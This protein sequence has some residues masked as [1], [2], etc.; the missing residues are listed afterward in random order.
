MTNTSPSGHNAVFD[1]QL[2]RSIDLL[3][4]LISRLK[5]KAIPSLE[6]VEICSAELKKLCQINVALKKELFQPLMTDLDN[7]LAIKPVDGN[8]NEDMQRLL[9]KAEKLKSQLWELEFEE[10]E[11]QTRPHRIISSIILRH[12]NSDEPIS[13]EETESLE[14]LQLSK[15]LSLKTII[16]ISSKGYVID[17]G[18]T[19]GNNQNPSYPSAGAIEA[20]DLLG[21]PITPTEDV[22]TE[23]P[24]TDAVGPQGTPPLEATPK[25]PVAEPTSEPESPEEEPTT[26]RYEEKTLPDAS[27]ECVIPDLKKSPY[28]QDCFCFASHFAIFDT[29]LT[30]SHVTSSCSSCERFRNK[31]GELRSKLSAFFSKLFENG[32]LGKVIVTSPEFRRR[33]NFFCLTRPAVEHISDLSEV[34]KRTD[35]PLAVRNETAEKV[36]RGISG[37]AHLTPYLQSGETPDG[38]RIDPII[39]NSIAFGF[40]VSR[41]KRFKSFLRFDPAR[42]IVFCEPRYRVFAQVGKTAG[43][44]YTIFSVSKGNI[45]ADPE[46]FREILQ[47]DGAIL[48]L[49]LTVD[50]PVDDAIQFFPEEFQIGT[51]IVGLKGNGVVILQKN[52]WLGLDVAEFPKPKIEKESASENGNEDSGAHEKSSADTE[53][54]EAADSSRPEAESSPANLQ[55]PVVDEAAAPLSE[56]RL[57]SDVPS[58]SIEPEAR[59]AATVPDS[60]D[61]APATPEMVL[62]PSADDYVEEDNLLADI[63][64]LPPDKTAVKDLAAALCESEDFSPVKNKKRGF[65]LIL[66]IL[67][68]E[69]NYRTKY[70]SDKQICTS[71]VGDA[72]LLCRAFADLEEES[73]IYHVLLKQ[74]AYATDSEIVERNYCF[75]D[76]SELLNSKFGCPVNLQQAILMRALFAPGI[77]GDY[78]LKNVAQGLFNDSAIWQNLP[79]VREVLKLLLKL[80][81][82]K[83]NKGY[84]QAMVNAICDVKDPREQLD[85]YAKEAQEL[86]RINS[87]LGQ[88]QSVFSQKLL[89][90]ESDTGVALKRLISNSLGDRELVQ[91]VLSDLS[92]DSKI[93]DAIKTAWDQRRAIMKVKGK[94]LDNKPVGG[95]VLDK[96]REALKKRIDL[97]NRWYEAT[98]TIEAPNKFKELRNKLL[99]AIDRAQKEL[100]KCQDQFAK[101]I[102]DNVLELMKQRL[103]GNMDFNRLYFSPT[104]HTGWIMLDK[105]YQPVFLN[106]HYESFVPWRNVLHHLCAEIPSLE[107]VKKK[108]GSPETYFFDNLGMFELI[109]SLQGGKFSP[110]DPPQDNVNRAKSLSEEIVKDYEGRIELAF[111]YGKI[112]EIAKET[113]RNGIKEFKEENDETLNFGFQKLF[114]SSID[115]QIEKCSQ[116][117]RKELSERIEKQQEKM[118]FP[119][120]KTVKRLIEEAKNY[121][122]AE[123]YLNRYE[124]DQNQD[125]QLI[126]D[127]NSSSDL[128]DF[129]SKDA[130]TNK[131]NLCSHTDDSFLRPE[132]LAQYF[133]IDSTDQDNSRSLIDSWNKLFAKSSCDDAKDLFTLWGF[134]VD[135]IR[136][137]ADKGKSK[138]RLT[139]RAS[140]KNLETYLTPFKEFG[141][142]PE[143]M[144]VLLVQQKMDPKGLV[145]TFNQNITSRISF[146]L[147]DKS[148]T[149]AN[150]RKITDI[151]HLDRD[152]KK[153]CIIVDK[154]LLAYLATKPQT[155]RLQALLNCALPFT[156]LNPFNGETGGVSDEMFRGRAKYLNAIM[157]SNM[158]SMLLYGGRQLGKTAILVRAANMM[159]KPADKEFAVFVP[160]KG[161]RQESNFAKI[162]GEMV[163]RVLMQQGRAKFDDIKTMCLYFSNKFHEGAINRLTLL[164]DETDDFLEACSKDNYKQLLPLINLSREPGTRFKFVFAGLHNVYRASNATSANS[165]LGQLDHMA[166]TPFTPY[167]ARQLLQDPLNYLGFSF[168]EDEKLELILCK[169]NYYPGILN[170]FGKSLLDAMSEKYSRHYS[171]SKENPPYKL[172]QN[173]LQEVIASQNMNSAINDKLSLTLNLD[174]RYNLLAHCI[175]WATYAVPLTCL[176]G[177]SIEQI[178]EAAN[179]LD[180]E[181]VFKDL[182]EQ[183]WKNLLLEMVEMALLQKVDDKPHFRLRKASFSTLFGLNADEVEQS[184][185]KTLEELG[186]NE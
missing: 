112:S 16:R 43:R 100:C 101:I 160:I 178:R 29:D 102:L 36:A 66:K 173:Q 68:R 132:A 64:A 10:A 23:T 46:E 153:T 148:I 119:L 158:N 177:A 71:S 89:G 7:F 19:D 151:F 105:Q 108:I 99:S 156:V 42:D 48:L 15:V 180:M 139:L 175:A 72:M 21:K 53:S 3:T 52:Q 104:L 141:T 76:I 22:K 1:Q 17:K 90:P 65:E 131:Y 34:L 145:D 27:W 136:R 138:F 9:E 11:R 103:N 147:W 171:A 2:Q 162:V 176:E 39:K 47:N 117:R 167:E 69:G 118:P 81:E 150:R 56:A 94:Y 159:N 25:T 55:K 5:D 120:L 78:D 33:Q 83:P 116:K 63:F 154:V 60:P 31:K 86:T 45:A 49:F 84:T 179:L 75:A 172:S 157:D 28:L 92:S 125:I 35:I 96:S 115:E 12:Q 57:E 70:D 123:E 54:T 144:D 93:D 50:D 62:A 185:Q 152:L 98:E 166:V 13:A 164:V 95:W 124:S 26:Y 97:L 140:S 149:L 127:E 4:D 24:S 74:L 32:L 163:L 143:S 186:A 122:V 183:D 80:H 146:I 85:K 41:A 6:E 134:N 88:C 73:G 38:T 79:S 91:I 44:W 170:F 129:L 126:A 130:Y 59:S 107:E 58:V 40:V 109:N 67:S 133:P 61:E 114:L 121:E 87:A 14:E 77:D 174:P 135:G 161:C 128:K 8:F 106:G 37:V 51:N 137:T 111:A 184:A 165:P 181:S 82:Q 168:E 169:S 30:V 20:G 155:A 110:G 113:M 18:K 182:K 142:A